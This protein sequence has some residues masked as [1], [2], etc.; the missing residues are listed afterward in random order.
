MDMASLTNSN[1]GASRLGQESD[2]LEIDPG[3]DTE[4]S[5]FEQ[6]SILTQSVRSSI[7]QYKVENSR[8]YHAYKE[9]QYFMLNDSAEHEHMELRH[10]AMLLAAGSQ[11]FY[12][13]VKNLHHILDLATKRYTYWPCAVIYGKKPIPVFSMGSAL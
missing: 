2:E 8:T 5:G 6:D 12:A 10:Q 13:P 1:A 4:D 9:G 7:Y 11:L 3:Y